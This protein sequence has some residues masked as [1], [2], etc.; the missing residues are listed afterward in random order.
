MHVDTMPVGADG[1]KWRN[2]SGRI[3][4][5]NWKGVSQ[6][7]NSQG[8]ILLLRE[9]NLQEE[10]YLKHVNPEEEASGYR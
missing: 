9:C 6:C 1:R 4:V 7:W 8:R 3:I 5:M 10:R 2:L